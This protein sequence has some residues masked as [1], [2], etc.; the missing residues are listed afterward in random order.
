MQSHKPN[1]SA[2]FIRQGPGKRGADAGPI[3]YVPL[4]STSVAAAAAAAN[5]AAQHA[6]EAP[7]CMAAAPRCAG[8]DHAPITR[9][10]PSCRASRSFR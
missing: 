4:T 9:S 1:D 3:V 5:A 6:G 8:A 7:L 2:E 10:R